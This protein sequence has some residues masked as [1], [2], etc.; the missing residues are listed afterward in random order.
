MERKKASLILIT[1]LLL[2][3]NPNN[4]YSHTVASSRKAEFPT[5][6]FVKIFQSLSITGC[7][8]NSKVCEAKTFNSVGSGVVVHRGIDYIHVLTAGHV[9]D[10]PMWSPVVEKEITSIE[11]NIAIQTHKN[12]FYNA[13]IISLTKVNEEK[14]DLCLLKID[15]VTLPA[16]KISKKGPVVGDKLYSMS[17]PAGIYHPP[18]VPILQGIYSGKMPDGKN[19]LSSIPA[20]GGSSGSPVLNERFELVGIL[21]ATHPAF[22]EISISS[23]FEELKKFLKKK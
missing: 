14:V 13:A 4:C 21:F 10:V 7:I 5:K 19:A 16:I 8:E 9:C 20:V 12:K 1:L 22:T 11:N 15:K 2:I 17:A 3:I 6:S 23:S 18:T